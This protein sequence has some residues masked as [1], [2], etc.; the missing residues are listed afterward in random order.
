MTP[1]TLQLSFPSTQNTITSRNKATASPSEAGKHAIFDLN[2]LID[3]KTKDSSVYVYS[4]PPTP[5]EV[6]SNPLSDLESSPELPQSISPE[7]QKYPE[8]GL[9]GWLV[10]FGAW[11]GWFAA[12]GIFNAVGSFQAYFSTQSVTAEHVLK[13]SILLTK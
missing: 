10:V 2:T 6:T 5:L 3:D 8:G 13:A 11:C 9:Q 4:V 1:I 12:F 7:E